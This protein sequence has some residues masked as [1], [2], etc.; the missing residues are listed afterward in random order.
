MGS[1]GQGVAEQQQ[2]AQSLAPLRRGRGEPASVDGAGL[3]QAGLEDRPE[4]ALE[5]RRGEPT[6]GRRREQET[7]GTIYRSFTL[8]HPCP[9]SLGPQVRSLD[10]RCR[11]RHHRRDHAAV[12]MPKARQRVASRAAGCPTG[13]TEL[14][15][16]W[17][18]G[19]EVG[20]SDYYVTM[21]RSGHTS[22]THRMTMLSFR[23]D[24][25]EAGRAQSW[26]DRLGVDRSELLRVALR[27]HIAL[28]GSELDAATWERVPLDEGEGALGEIAD[29]GPAEDWSDW[30]DAAG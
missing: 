17:A 25:A 18:P 7:S 4:P 20:H 11:S 29:W 8:R 13:L 21:A 6:L 30:A 2:L 23:V 16:G 1:S 3:A 5:D 10:R 24:E 12:H 9:P 22:Y 15:A 19:D 28:L 27:R 14:P 26:A